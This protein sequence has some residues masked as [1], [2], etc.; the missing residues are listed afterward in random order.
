VGGWDG[1]SQRTRHRRAFAE[2]QRNTRAHVGVHASRLT[3][4]TR[5][6]KVSLVGVFVFEQA[7]WASLAPPSRKKAIREATPNK[8]KSL[9]EVRW[10]IAPLDQRPYSRSEQGD[11]KIQRVAQL[12]ILEAKPGPRGAQA[13]TPAIYVY[14]YF[15]SLPNSFQTTNL[16]NMR[17]TQMRT[18]RSDCTATALTTAVSFS[19]NVFGAC[20]KLK[21]KHSESSV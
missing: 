6:Y 4:C 7:S 1:A 15:R 3:N 18:E 9:S 10:S 20:S 14:T 12:S 8:N 19:L 11:V 17:D 16:S 5:T 2:T 21:L 13:A